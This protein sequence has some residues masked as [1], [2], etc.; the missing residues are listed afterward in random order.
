MTVVMELIEGKNLHQWLIS[1]NHREGLF[2]SEA[3]Q[4]FR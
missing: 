3:R 2:E 1:K 4:V